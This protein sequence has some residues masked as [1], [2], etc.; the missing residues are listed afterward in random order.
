M[1]LPPPAHAAAA[2]MARKTEAETARPKIARMCRSSRET[3]SGSPHAAPLS[4]RAASHT[5]ARARPAI[6]RMVRVSEDLTTTRASLRRGDAIAD[7]QAIAEL[8]ARFRHLR[9]DRRSA[10]EAFELVD[11][12]GA[13]R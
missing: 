2:V 8:V 6:R 10:D 12:R 9:R 3:A 1:F 5:G 4:R 11:P 13:A 7:A